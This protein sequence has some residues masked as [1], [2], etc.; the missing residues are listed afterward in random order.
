MN[1]RDRNVLKTEHV[2]PWW[3]AYTFDNPI[4]GM[5][6][7]PG[8]I[9]G[10][11]IRP[12][13][14][15]ADIGCGMGFFSLG[16][17]R[18]VGPAGRVIAI[19]MQ[20]KMLDTVLRR[21]KRAGLADRIRAHRCEPN[22]LGIPESLDFALGFWM[23]HEI[24]EKSTFFREIGAALKPGGR[25]LMAEPKMHVGPA[26]FEETVRVATGA[27]LEPETAMKIRLSRAMLF[28]VRSTERSV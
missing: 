15:V 25:F 10:Q 20:E 26:D 13:H 21:A 16:M 11:Y 1:D 24:A 18:L 3:L 14:T 7:H 5:F 22:R 12:G 27:G 28:G 9:L 19:D 2:C 17:A 23:V 4:R 6:H 8:K